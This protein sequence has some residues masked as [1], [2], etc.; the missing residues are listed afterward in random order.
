M[1]HED[2]AT[3]AIH[4]GRSIIDAVRRIDQ[5]MGASRTVEF[6][7][8]AAV[9]T[10]LVVTGATPGRSRLEDTSFVGLAPNLAARIQ[11]L[12][13]PNEIVVAEL[14]RRIAGETFVWIDGGM[15]VLKGFDDPVRIYRVAGE[16]AGASRLGGAWA[17]HPPPW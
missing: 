10:G 3:A 17:S 7:V 1:A 4:A 12:A 5:Q 14:T 15:H 16:V 2:A 8:R 11:H 9:T 6:A 13:A